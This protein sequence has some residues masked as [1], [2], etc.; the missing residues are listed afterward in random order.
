MSGAQAVRSDILGDE[1]RRAP[2]RPRDPKIDTV[3]LQAAA[4]VYSENGWSGFY[5]DAVARRAGVSKS[6]IYRRWPSREDL[7]IDAVNSVDLRS[8]LD[9][10]PTLRD[11]LSWLVRHQ[12]SWWSETGRRAYA[13]LAMDRGTHPALAELYDTR[14]ITPLR[15]GVAG[16]VSRAVAAGEIP[17][18]DSEVLLVECLSG[19]VFNRM[20]A[21]SPDARRRLLNDPDRYVTQLVDFLMAG[22]GSP[23]STAD[24]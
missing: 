8:I 4:E 13:W 21:I 7:L 20:N 3:V 18:G 17:A 12:L 14:V 6:A 2:G 11:A 10:Q 5:F 23:R 22:A 16:V 19:A 15:E 9:E 24:R 1:S